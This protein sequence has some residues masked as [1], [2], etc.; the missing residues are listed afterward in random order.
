MRR[1]TTSRLALLSEGDID[2]ALSDYDGRSS[3][4]RDTPRLCWTGA[5]SLEKGWPAKGL[6]DIDQALSLDPDSAYARDVRADVLAALGRGN[7]AIAVCCKS[8]AIE[9]G[10]QE[11]VQGLKALQRG[12]P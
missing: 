6:L 4:D 7:E 2:R 8:L 5:G 9:P 11:S 12:K 10:M 3:S 1:D